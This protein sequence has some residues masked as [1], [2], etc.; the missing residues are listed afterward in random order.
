MRGGS[1]MTGCVKLYCWVVAAAALLAVSQPALAEKRVALVIGNSAHQNV[2]PLA[3]PVNDSTRIAATLKAAVFD[4]VVS[5]RDLPA[6]EAKR[7]LLDFADPA[8]AA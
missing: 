3:N 1:V 2:A 6:A 5:R 7:A 4:V 8:R